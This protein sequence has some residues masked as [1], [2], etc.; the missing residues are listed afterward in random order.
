MCKC[1]LLAH[2]MF[3]AHK[4]EW[5][6]FYDRT[7]WEK[8]NTNQFNYGATNHPIFS[9]CNI[10]LHFNLNWNNKEIRLSFCPILYIFCQLNW[11]FVWWGLEWSWYF[12]DGRPMYLNTEIIF[13]S[14]FC[15]YYSHSDTNFHFLTSY[16][17]I[18]SSETLSLIFKCWFY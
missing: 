4:Y 6:R 17:F 14:S 1:F 2:S 5:N 3:D 15:C 10:I 11:I 7:V 9:M 13:L 12:D 18:S 16:L 8:K